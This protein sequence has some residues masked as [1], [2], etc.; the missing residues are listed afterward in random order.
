MQTAAFFS[1]H[2]IHIFFVAFGNA[3]NFTQRIAPRVV[4]RRRARHWAGIKSLHLVGAKTIFLEPNSEIHHIL[5]AST[6]MG[7]NKIRN[8]ELFFTR[9]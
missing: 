6:R 4:H 1:A 5:I 9:F 2:D 7:G 3:V 8:Q